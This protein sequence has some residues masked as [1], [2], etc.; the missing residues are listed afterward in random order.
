MPNRFLVVNVGVVHGVVNEA[1]VIN[2]G[3]QLCA[4]NFAVGRQTAHAHAAKVNTV[5]GFFTTNEHIA[6][7]FATGTVIGQRH[8]QRSVCR[9]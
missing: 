8:L 5:I 6:M 7:A 9:L 2:S 1:H 3:Q 4:I